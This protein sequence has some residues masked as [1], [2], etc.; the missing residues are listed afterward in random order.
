[1]TLPFVPLHIEKADLKA[2]FGRQM[3]QAI[4]RRTFFV[5]LLV[6]DTFSFDCWRRIECECHFCSLFCAVFEGD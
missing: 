4:T 1:M 6:S 2:M 5:A 3:S